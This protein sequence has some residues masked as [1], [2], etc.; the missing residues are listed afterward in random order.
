MM[1][2]WW[3]QVDVLQYQV[4]QRGVDHRNEQFSWIMPFM[5]NVCTFILGI[6]HLQGKSNC[7]IS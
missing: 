4:D 6:S 5:M 7:Y 1:I 2:W 3:S